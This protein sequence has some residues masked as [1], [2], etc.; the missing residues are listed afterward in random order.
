M[1]YPV[2]EHFLTLQG[3]G[4][5]SGQAAYFIRLG[6]CNVGCHWCDVKESWPLHAHPTHAVEEMVSWVQASGAPRAVITGGEPTLHHL[7]P[8]TAA[9]QAAGTA[10]HLETAGTNPLTGQWTWVTFSPKKF[11]APLPEYYSH[12]HELKVVVHNRHDLQW[13]EG[14]AQRMPPE[15]VLFLQPEWFTPA[16]ASWVVEYALHHPHWRVSLQTHKYLQIP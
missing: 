1:H 16:S 7:G 6:G 13:A 3:E 9:L 14:H 12:A 4:A 15:A 2:M 8:L 11:K 10:T 5:F